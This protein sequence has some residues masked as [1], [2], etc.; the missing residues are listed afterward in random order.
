MQ[1]LFAIVTSARLSIQAPSPIH[2]LLPIASNHGYLMFT[3]GLIT[4][5]L[6]IL[7][8]NILNINRLIP[9]NGKNGETNSV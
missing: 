4:T 9:L 2:E 6:P 1:Q 3:R 7:A 5:P 8:P